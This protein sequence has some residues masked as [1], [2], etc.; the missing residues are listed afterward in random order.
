MIT[1]TIIC[2]ENSVVKNLLLISEIKEPEPEPPMVL[3]SSILQEALPPPPPSEG[4]PPL[5]PSFL[6]EDII[7]PPDIL[8]RWQRSSRSGR[9]SSSNSL[10][11]DA[12]KR[13]SSSSLQAE[14]SSNSMKSLSFQNLCSKFDS[15]DISENE[16]SPIPIHS[17]MSEVRSFN[18][19]NLRSAGTS[20]SVK[21]R[22][23]SDSAEPSSDKYITRKHV[24]L[25]SMSDSHPIPSHLQPTRCRS[26]VT[27]G[28]N[29]RTNPAISQECD[30]NSAGETWG[31]AKYGVV[32]NMQNRGT[33]SDKYVKASLTLSRNSSL[34]IKEP[35]RNKWNSSFA[36]THFTSSS[37]EKTNFSRQKSSSATNLAQLFQPGSGQLRRFG[38]QED[39]LDQPGRLIKTREVNLESKKPETAKPFS[40]NEKD[41]LTTV[42][43]AQKDS[44]GNTKSPRI[45]VNKYG[46]QGGNNGSTVDSFRTKRIVSD[47]TEIRMPRRGTPV[48]KK[49]QSEA[50]FQLVDTDNEEEWEPKLD[51]PSSNSITSIFPWQTELG[52]KASFKATQNSRSTVFDHLSRTGRDI[53]SDEAESSVSS[54]VDDRS[55]SK[56]GSSGDSIR[57]GSHPQSKAE[58]TAN[59]HFRSTYPSVSELRDSQFAHDQVDFDA[60]LRSI[61]EQLESVRQQ[62]LEK[63]F[64]NVGK[65][66]Y[67]LFCAVLTNDMHN[68]CVFLTWLCSFST[69]EM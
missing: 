54:S 62:I 25:R 3:Q 33:M 10:D 45:M 51:L 19:S 63:K 57:F 55:A 47:K 42:K 40:A 20:M 9:S 64:E 32:K 35:S 58:E 37:S 8:R 28:E 38:S 23:S 46:I 26:P 16:T 49:W 31:Y 44:S 30:R 68:V 66:F 12:D 13:L 60:K 6:G 65:V 69:S 15:T 50:S 27:E 18:P 56:T 21:T 1:H 53:S 43:T 11:S 7:K 14:A 39:G 4:P 48:M 17:I 67:E 22:A 5:K 2:T 41:T 59:P 34:N 24:P 52:R 36:N 29:S 61:T